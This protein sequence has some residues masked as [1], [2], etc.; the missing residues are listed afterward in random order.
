[1][2]NQTME[3][4]IYN[5]LNDCDRRLPTRVLFVDFNFIETMN[6]EEM[7]IHF[8]GPILD[9]SSINGYETYVIYDKMNESD[10]KKR[11]YNLWFDATPV[12]ISEIKDL[13][14][15][16]IAATICTKRTYQK[17]VNSSFN[18]FYLVL[19]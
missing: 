12:K 14:N 2:Y 10:V 9:N 15:I 3:D 16:K 4:N 1:M 19:Q 17:L 7:F 18:S 13:K 6:K 5:I 11:L 8:I